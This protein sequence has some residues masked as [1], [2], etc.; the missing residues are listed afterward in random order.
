MSAAIN[1]GPEFSR[2]VPLT[3]L[4][5][6]PYRQEIVASEAERDALARRFELVSLDRLTAEIELVR[7]PSGTILLAASFEAVFEQECIVTLDPVAGSVA[8]RFQLRYGRPEAEEDAP[9]GDDDPAFEPLTGEAI[10]IGEA[11]AQEFS[12]ALPPFP[13][14]ADAVIEIDDPETSED[15][16]FSALDK[17]RRGRSQ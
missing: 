10:D 17:F 7:E 11:V 8:E 6:E 9:S 3:R 2:R 5:G 12:L 14:A 4:G 1:P 16:P 13:R 15:G